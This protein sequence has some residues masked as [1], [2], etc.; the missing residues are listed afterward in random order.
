MKGAVVDS[1]LRVVC[2]LQT[3]TPRGQHPDKI[4]D[5]MAAALGAL[6]AAAGDEPVA[7]G[8][9]VPGIV[10]EARG[11]G[12]Y[13]ASLGWRDISIAALIAERT[14]LPVAF[15]HDVRSG[16]LAECRL[17]AGQ[18]A[19]NVVFLPIGT[20]IA[21]AAVVDG[22]LLVADGYAGEIGHVIVEP[23]GDLCP[24]GGRGCLETLASASAIARRYTAL[25]GLKMSAATEVEKRLRAGDEI[26]QQVW[27]EAV[28]AL[29]TAL[30]MTITLLGPEVIVI[31]G[32]L[33]KAGNLLLEPLRTQ[34]AERLT[35]QRSPKVVA[36]ALGDRAGCMGAAIL[37]LDLG[38][39]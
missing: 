18:N 34:I 24:C 19:N 14:G 20:S 29:A 22:R 3:P 12:V 9:V 27:A 36:A 35:F 17:G 11:V 37:A 15:G 31:G 13:S 2:T 16:A 25:T 4:V 21:G 10:D 5:A 32:G 39:T 26:A 38:G 1:D 30:T 23:G 6:V 7:A 8:V 28:A 33:S